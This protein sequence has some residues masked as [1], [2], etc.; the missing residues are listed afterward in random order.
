[1][2]DVNIAK[3]FDPK[4]I[5][6]DPS[7][8]TPNALQGDQ[9][10]AKESMSNRDLA[11]ASINKAAIRTN[12]PDDNYFQKPFSFN[13][14][15]DG[16]NFER[17]YEHPKFK[18]LGFSPFRDNETYYNQRSSLMDDT[19]RAFPQMFKMAGLA[20][21]DIYGN[22]TDFT[23]AEPSTGSSEAMRK[24]MAIGSSSRDTFGAKAV[25]FGLNMGYTVGI[26]TSILAEEFA[27][28]AAEAYTMGGATPLVAAKTGLNA[29]KLT[30]AFKRLANTFDA[31]KDIYKAKQVWDVS[32]GVGAFSRAVLPFQNT[33]DLFRDAGKAAQGWD[34][35]SDY[36]K[37]YKRFGAFYRDLRELNLVTSEAKLEGGGVQ[38]QT[39]QKLLGE[40]RDL[41]G[42]DPNEAEYKDIYAQARK[43]GFTASYA[44][45]AGIYASNKVVLNRL[46][47]GV[48]GIAAA[49]HRAAKAIKSSVIK[50]ANWKALGKDPFS[51]VKGS[52]Y[53]NKE[54]L[55]Q[56]I[57]SSPK[58]GL[59]FLTA[60]LMEGTQEVYQE[61]VAEAVTDYYVNTFNQPTQAHRAIMKHAIEH[62]LKSQLSGQGLEVFLSG[63]LMAA[64]MQAAGGALKWGYDYKNL[65]QL[66]KQEK[67]FNA[68][69]ANA[70][71]A[72]PYTE[73][74]QR[75]KDW[76]NQVVT[77]LNELTKN[78]PEFL[79]AVERN[80]NSQKDLAEVFE[81]ATLN[82][83]KHAA[84]N[85]KDDALFEHVSTLIES[86]TTDLFKDQLRDLRGLD[87]SEL[88]A[89]FNVKESEGATIRNRIDKSLKRIEEIEEQ[90]EKAKNIVN[91]YDILKNPLE[92]L[93]FK[94][95]V[96]LMVYNQFSFD[97]IGS[98]MVSIQQDLVKKLGLGKIDYTDI[99]P[100]FS[101]GKSSQGGLD[102]PT[103]SMGMDYEIELLDEQIKIYKEGT[104]EQKELAKT[105]EEKKSTLSS[106][107]IAVQ[108]LVQSL[109]L[110]GKANL[111]PE[112]TKE[113]ADRLE[114]AQS[115]LRQAFGNHIKSLNKASGQPTLEENIDDA[116]SS[117]LDYWK[118]SND[119]TYVANA[120]NQL[121][122]PQ[123][124]KNNADRL[125]EALRA[126]DAIRASK[127]KETVIEYRAR[128]AK[129][130][131]LND[132]LEK[133]NAYVDFDEADAYTDNEKV[134]SVFYDADTGKEISPFSDP[135]KYNEILQLID[136]YDDQHFKITGKRLF[137]PNRQDTGVRVAGKTKDTDRIVGQLVGEFD[138]EDKRTYDE[139]AE[140]F[141][142]D[143]K[144][145]SSSVNAE[146]VL[147]AI[148]NS[149][150]SSQVQKELARK[151][152]TLVD[153]TTLIT[154]RK[155]LYVHSAYTPTSGILVDARFSSSDFDNMVGIPMEY[156][157]LNA[158]GQKVVSDALSSD[159]AFSDKM[160]ELLQ[161]AK[162]GISEKDRPYYGYALN[163]KLNFVME[164]L[165]NP[166][167]QELLNSIN[168]AGELTK[169][170]DE[171]KTLWGSFLD[172]LKN[173]L[174]GL[175]NI[176]DPTLL[177]E[178]VN[179][180]TNK[181]S[182]TSIPPVKEETP[183]QAPTGPTQNIDY[184]DPVLIKKL[185][186]KYE[187]VLANTDPQDRVGMSFE[188]WLTTEDAINIAIAHSIK[189]KVGEEGAGGNMTREAIVRKLTSVGYTIQELND[190]SDTEIND[191]L[192][193]FDQRVAQFVPNLQNEDWGDVDVAIKKAFD[194][195]KAENVKLSPDNTVYQQEVVIEGEPV[196]REFQ[197]VSNVVKK[198]SKSKPDEKS[199]QRGNIVDRLFKSF[200]QGKLQSI[201]EFEKEY[202]VIQK[203]N[204]LITFDNKA[205]K[206]LFDTARTT[207]KKLNAAGLKVIPDFP[208]IFGRLGNTATAGEMDILAYNK[209]GDVF[210][211]DIKTV[212]DAN[213]RF[214]YEINQEFK[215]ILGDRYYD[216]ITVLSKNRN[217]MRASLEEFAEIDADLSVALTQKFLDIT[218]RYERESNLLQQGKDFK[219]YL[220][221]QDDD[222]K[223]QL[224]YKELLRQ[225]TGLQVS[226]LSILPITVTTAPGNTS[227]VSGAR[228]IGDKI[229]GADGKLI[230]NPK[231]S[232]LLS[233]DNS[234]TIYD[235]NIPD[236]EQTIDSYP[237]NPI[238]K[239]VAPMQPAPVVKTEEEVII[240]EEENDQEELK[241]EKTGKK[242]KDPKANEKAAVK[243]KLK[244]IR[245]AINKI[246]TKDELSKFK[247][248]LTT[249]QELGILDE[250]KNKQGVTPEVFKALMDQKIKQVDNQITIAQLTEPEGIV[251][252]TFMNKKGEQR[253]GLVMGVVDG[254]KLEIRD[255]T[256]E[257]ETSPSDWSFA[258]SG[259]SIIL[260]ERDVNKQVIAMNIES[261]IEKPDAR[262][263]TESN[264]A[265]ATAA[266]DFEASKE[267]LKKLDLNNPNAAD[268]AASDLFDKCDL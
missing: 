233:I 51:I 132:L 223:Q 104:P 199:T 250:I 163:N 120:I 177:N 219:T 135:V 252:F 62:G 71:K 87:D 66:K 70:G 61:G 246:E 244:D 166:D 26:A 9:T 125:T 110:A 136:F 49:E 33:A 11:I 226:S 64:P 57:A 133:F 12:V 124:F 148:I 255:I 235:L 95:A 93:G 184:T 242:P 172:S 2:E 216:F 21:S 16:Y 169:Q 107:N 188:S 122:N 157:V 58:S 262:T 91:P 254:T 28:A 65:Y 265:Q 22:W 213:R 144:A 192:N 266:E 146:T 77:A 208:I 150:F 1:M 153:P 210:I 189:K 181:L 256:D 241:N 217:F 190:M 203:D 264:N 141:G 162:A 249:A 43:A 83:D 5:S 114:E 126:A 98:R 102:T 260:S 229:L 220:G 231:G 164:V 3:D 96:K 154:F 200:L 25:N 167:F 113:F 179:V 109:N 123:V 121:Y 75:E 6:A 29:M 180:I 236:I 84:I 196:T 258:G 76:D 44:N 221:Y 253:T 38:V 85:S 94:E 50:N 60:N 186:D 31:A 205:L 79:S 206:E 15:I 7:L 159:Q 201:E 106:L 81:E 105:L 261:K 52:R 74:I 59:R 182:S 176:L 39:A 214:S 54:W 138:P 80:V 42:R 67:R 101:K 100:L 170:T 222:L 82:D 41:K 47:K 55:K 191:I 158:I 195:V 88:A 111:T 129:N 145:E 168:Y 115:L 73:A 237:E 4:P 130:S 34:A 178:A 46:L 19:R 72:N 257:L 117:Y 48:P 8:L 20:V 90:T 27:L 240:E 155:N 112:Q 238:K 18:Q 183:P 212:G 10:P 32:K 202:K 194:D 118:L 263:K 103:R 13:A 99:A 53:L 30:A 227:V 243:R 165:N 234:R 245:A 259:K 147:K 142:F 108:N 204:P 211:I 187:A 36:A 197:R 89:A 140:Q 224:A 116:F 215:K 251:T 156:S 160:D 239:E 151:L 40:F 225:R 127:A 17:Y 143:K 267:E 86:G 185:R 149:K 92:Y 131:F 45:M 161:L 247:L 69:P 128:Y 198:K 35:L 23:S 232:L 152:L 37:G 209:K 193:N 137:K 134:P 268:D 139:I 97:R 230:D 228:L 63:F 173:L 174:N 171:A 218:D 248:L 24:A 207:Q 119:K 56:S 175:L 14:G 68:D 78:S